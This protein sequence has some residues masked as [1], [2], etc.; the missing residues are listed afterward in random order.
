MHT[1]APCAIGNNV[2]LY[3]VLVSKVTR[4]AGLTLS[5]RVFA[6]DLMPRHTVAIILKRNKGL[7]VSCAGGAALFC[8]LY[9]YLLNLD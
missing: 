8:L 1:K 9:I 3:T 4:P 7:T 6:A 5:V 2:S